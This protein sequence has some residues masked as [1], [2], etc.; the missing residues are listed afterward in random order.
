MLTYQLPNIP[1][2]RVVEPSVKT[3]V[4]EWSEAEWRWGKRVGRPIQS[5]IGVASPAP[6]QWL[7]MGACHGPTC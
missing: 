2:L 3:P 5:P 7:R 1:F 6:W 4:C